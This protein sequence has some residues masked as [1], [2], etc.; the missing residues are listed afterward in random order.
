[1]T[2]RLD[3]FHCES[4]PLVCPREP[5]LEFV[6]HTAST[7]RVRD[8]RDLEVHGLEAA[9]SGVGRAEEGLVYGVER[10]LVYG[11]YVGRGADVVRDGAQ[12]G[13]GDSREEREHLV[14]VVFCDLRDDRDEGDGVQSGLD[15]LCRT[16]A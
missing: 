1:M 11:V 4:S 9:E 8:L 10:V 15:H 6:L 5:L 16:Q 14:R 3:N 13:G 2:S 12:L 7:R